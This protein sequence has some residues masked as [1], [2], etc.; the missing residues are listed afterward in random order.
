MVMIGLARQAMLVPLEPLPE[1]MLL[2]EAA[3]NQQIEGP[4]NG[5]LPDALTPS[6]QV[7]LDL[8][9]RKMGV[10]TEYGLRHHLPLLCDGEPLIPQVAVE[11]AHKGVNGGKRGWGFHHSSSS[12]QASR[13]AGSPAASR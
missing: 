6:L 13:R 11:K 7:P 9:H 10:R 8:I 12:I 4:V 1:I 2:H 3:P 5:R